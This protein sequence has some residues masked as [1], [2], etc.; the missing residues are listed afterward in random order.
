MSQKPMTDP[1]QVANP[2]NYFPVMMDARVFVALHPDVMAQLDRIEARLNISLPAPLGEDVVANLKTGI[3]N[4]HGII[5]VQRKVIE[6]LQVWILTN[7]TAEKRTEIGD[8]L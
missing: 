1:E 2:E 3:N 8:L 7:S 4:L 5:E 6:R